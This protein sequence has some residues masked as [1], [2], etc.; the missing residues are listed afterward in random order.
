M[1]LQTK[2]M[3]LASASQGI[4]LAILLIE[5]YK[6][7]QGLLQ[8][9]NQMKQIVLNRSSMGMNI[10][11]AVLEAAKA[12]FKNPILAIAG[13]AAAAAGAAAIYGMVGKAKGHA[14][15]GFAG[16]DGGEVAPSDTVPA[17]LT[18]GELVLNAAQQRNVAGGMGSSPAETNKLLEDTKEQNDQVIS[19]L[20]QARVQHAA[21]MGT[22]KSAI[23]RIPMA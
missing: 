18:P 7:R 6:T 12:A 16:K 10:A 22:L 13:I 8:T 11:Q 5:Q 14:G 20:K 9:L 21:L 17:M 15:G 23:D 19:E 4:Q 3:A 1:D 2:L